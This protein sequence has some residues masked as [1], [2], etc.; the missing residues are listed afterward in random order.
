MSS[1]FTSTT[2]NGTH[3]QL[4]HDTF[5]VDG[6]IVDTTGA[7]AMSQPSHL[8]TEQ[9]SYNTD[10]FPM[11][12]EHNSSL[13][14]SHSPSDFQPANSF[15][16]PS[17]ILYNQNGFEQNRPSGSINHLSPTSYGGTSS[18]HEPVS[19]E[20]GCSGATPSL[21]DDFPYANFANID[22][23]PTTLPTVDNLP[24]P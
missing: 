9:P 6:Y 2:P 3:P 11:L 19:P 23:E 17:G 13:A 20:N 15:L 1:T 4:L 8:S 24:L 16:H 22:D 21:A 18:P 12:Q 5:A 10:I 7:D 14:N